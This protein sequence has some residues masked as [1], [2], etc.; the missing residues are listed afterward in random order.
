M[1]NTEHMTATMATSR[2]GCLKHPAGLAIAA[3]GLLLAGTP[4]AMAACSP[5]PEFKTTNLA[6]LQMTVGRVFI[7]PN[8][9]VGTIYPS[10]SPT[11]GYMF[12]VN[13]QTDV[14]PFTCPGGGSL[15]GRVLSGG[16]QIDSDNWFTTNVEGIAIQL[17]RN[18]GGVFISYPHTIPFR[19]PEFDTVGFFQSDLKFVVR[20]KKIARVTGS[21][22]LAEGIYSTYTGD[23]SSTSVLTT[24]VLGDA[25][26]IVTPTCTV[27][28]GSKTVNVPLGKQPRSS[29]KG[30]NSTSPAT[31][32]NIRLNCNAGVGS[33]LNQVYLRMDSNSAV[34]GV[35]GLL[36]LTPGV[37][38]ATGV[39]IQVRDWNDVLVEFGG[40]GSFA[41]VSKDGVFDLRYTARYIQTGPSVTTGSAN[42]TATFTINY[43]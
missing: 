20:L 30:I 39:G 28:T 9:P 33:P 8:D 34:A 41:G 36:K 35:P 11:D 31:P 27:D 25:I 26:T 18:R 7:S 3:L 19:G 38:N 22:R 2:A 23:G 37:G 32:F 10:N 4:D 43:K 15:L 6:P 21:G 5:H 13:P 24:Q 40:S 16:T 17:S 42:S 14:P 12:P 1:K 29:F